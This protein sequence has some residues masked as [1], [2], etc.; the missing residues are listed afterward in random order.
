M[1]IIGHIPEVKEV[2]CRDICYTLK[3][4]KELAI[5]EKRDYTKEIKGIEDCL[6]DFYEGVYSK[7]DRRYIQP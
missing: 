1:K 6:K 7:E 4:W 5:I 2:E 3:R